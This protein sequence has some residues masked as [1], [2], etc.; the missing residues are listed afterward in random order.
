MTMRL[1]LPVS[2][3]F[4]LDGKRA[5]VTG[6]GRGLG[7]AAATAL[8][9]AGAAVTLAARSEGELRSACEAITGQGGQAD[10]LVLDVTD[11]KAVAAAIAE[12]PAF[13]ILVNNAGMNRP[14]PLVDTADEDIDAVFDLNVKAT[15]YVT[16]EVTR[17]LLA[18]GEK[19]SIINVSSQMGHVGGPRRTLYCATKHAVEG[20]TKALAWEL[21]SAGIRVNTVCPTFIET[22]F[23]APMFADTV[24]RDFV[25]SK[26]ALG[27]IGRVDEVM[28]PIVFLA[29]EASSLMTGSALMLDGGWTAA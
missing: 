2:S 1:E 9:Q 17:R 12:R 26:I 14:K 19:G 15:F 25:V 6:A 7:L 3:G 22:A 4:R 20:M 29:S 24:F 10:Y 5:L 23:T 21:G 27:R 16:R 11:S 18:A 13:H 28:G 8:A